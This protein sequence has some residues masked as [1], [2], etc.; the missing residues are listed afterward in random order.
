MKVLALDSSGMTASV[1]IVEDNIVIG[2]YNVTYKKTHS[3]TL[4]PMLDEVVK[5]TE[6]DLKQID[7]IAISS[8]PGSFTG[9]RIGS[10]TAK[11]LAQG[12]ELPVIEVPTLE[13]MAY[14]L[15]G[16]ECLICPMMDARRNQAFTGLYEWKN[17]DFTTVEGQMAVPVEEIINKANSYNKKVIYLG[18]GAIAFRQQIEQLSAVPYRIAPSY[19]LNQRAAAVAARAIEYYNRQDKAHIV[20]AKDHAPVYLRMSQAERER[21]EKQKKNAN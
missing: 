14:Q 4:L 11:G 21:M 19:A 8:G 16:T 6:T 1:A 9:L 20:D 5:M 13:A 18:D 3:Q 17:D 15:F 7:A 10:A 2:E 12:L